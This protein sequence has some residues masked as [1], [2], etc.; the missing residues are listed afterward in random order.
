MASGPKVGVERQEWQQTDCRVPGNKSWNI[1]AANKLLPWTFCTE[2][3]IG[4]VRRKDFGKKRLT[5]HQPA[6]A[7]WLLNNANNLLIE[8]SFCRRISRK[9]LGRVDR[10]PQ[11]MG[12]VRSAHLV[13]LA[14]A[15]D[16]LLADRQALPHKVSQA[17]CRNLAHLPRG[18]LGHDEL[19][20]LPCHRMILPE[21]PKN[22]QAMPSK[23]A[24]WPVRA[25]AARMRHVQIDCLWRLL[26]MPH[27]SSSD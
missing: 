17:S 22:D 3:C 25:R 19:R 24:H 11:S 13:C 20:F 26:R 1:S 9:K 2:I 16:M 8:P 4:S 7:C 12:S 5:L 15:P 14:F 27:G 18:G 6:S 23:Q 21:L 10:L